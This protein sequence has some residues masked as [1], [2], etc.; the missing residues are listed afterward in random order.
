MWSSCRQRTALA[1]R[2]DVGLLVGDGWCRLVAESRVPELPSSFRRQP[3][4]REKKSRITSQY[5]WIIHRPVLLTVRLSVT[6]CS[7]PVWTLELQARVADRRHC[8]S[9]HFDHLYSVAQKTEQWPYW[10]KRRV[11]VLFTVTNWFYPR[12]AM[13]A[14]YLQ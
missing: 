10:V 1:I 5:S 12:D 11:N 7:V 3:V 8:Q 2:V 13:L 6:L 9:V 14:R 4:W